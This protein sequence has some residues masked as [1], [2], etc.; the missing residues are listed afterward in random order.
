MSGVVGFGDGSG[1]DA[2]GR[3]SCP[4]G[5]PD[6]MNAVSWWPSEREA[7]VGS[8]GGYVGGGGCGRAVGNL[9]RCYPDPAVSV[10]G[11]R[12]NG[13]NM[14]PP[15]CRC[16][17]G[18]VCLYIYTTI[19]IHPLSTRKIFAKTITVATV[20]KQAEDRTTCWST[21]GNHYMEVCVLFLLYTRYIPL[22]LSK[23]I[24]VRRV[25]ILVPVVVL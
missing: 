19:G 15:L 7:A 3:T 17:F 16:I 10:S 4:G 12:H 25:N 18:S 21:D 2:H 14:G 23:G 5:A 24:V 13:R 20:P 11:H 9:K 8:N 22:I 1:S 6:H